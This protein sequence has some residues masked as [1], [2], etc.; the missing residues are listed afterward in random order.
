V[1]HHIRI[2]VVRRR[3]IESTAGTTICSTNRNTP[4]FIQPIEHPAFIQQRLISV[5]QNLNHEGKKREATSI[6]KPASAAPF[7]KHQTSDIV[8]N[9]KLSYFS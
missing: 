8:N 4:F 1:A 2:N 6:T 9:G 3:V 7:K 5:T